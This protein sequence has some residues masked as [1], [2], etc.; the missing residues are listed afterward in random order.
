MVFSRYVAA[1]SAA[2]N[3]PLIYLYSRVQEGDHS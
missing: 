3:L 1:V 2:I